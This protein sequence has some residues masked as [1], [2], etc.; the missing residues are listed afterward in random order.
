MIIRD[1]KIIETSY[2]FIEKILVYAAD[3]AAEDHPYLEE[4]CHRINW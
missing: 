3:R 4:F 1:N 2:K